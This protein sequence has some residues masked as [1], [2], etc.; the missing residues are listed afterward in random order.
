MPVAPPVIDQFAKILLRMGPLCHWAIDEHCRFTQAA[1]DTARLFQHSPQE[2]TGRGIAEVSNDR[3]AVHWV[4]ALGK[5]FAG[6]ALVEEISFGD[7]ESSYFLTHLPVRNE[8]GRVL[9]AAGFVHDPRQWEVDPHSR[10]GDFLQEL[11][12]QRAKTADFLHD[13][14][15]QSLSAAGLQ[16]DLLRMDLE[17]TVPE[18]AS[19]TTE[20]Q[21]LLDEALRR[22]REFNA[23]HLKPGV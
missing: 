7:P 21:R 1:G 22:V 12:A 2:L 6:E 15:A 14:V 5:V 9:F 3:M 16:L 10:N 23:A 11:H 18:I 19:R 13:D 20:I 17:S 4:L 8:K